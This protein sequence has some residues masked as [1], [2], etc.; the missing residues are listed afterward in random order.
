MPG[1]TARHEERAR[2][3]NVED[4]LPVAL[5]DFFKRAPDLAENAARV[6]DQDVRRP[7]FGFDRGDA[8]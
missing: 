1:A 2:E 8:A 6:V 7:A 3:I 4:R 5:R